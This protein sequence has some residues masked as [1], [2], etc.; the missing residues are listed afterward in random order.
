MKAKNNLKSG[1]FALLPIIVFFFILR[2]I[3]NILFSISNNF[4]LLLPKYWIYDSNSEIPF[5]WHIIAIISMLSIVWIIGLLVNHYY[6]GKKIRK[7]SQPMINKIPVLNTLFRVSKQAG[8]TL[9]NKN[10]FKEVVLVEFPVP[11]VYSIGFITGANTS[12][13]EN[14]LE[15]DVVSVFSPTTPNPT[16]GFLILVKRNSVKKI[17]MSVQEAIEYIIS[18]GTVDIKIKDKILVS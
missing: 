10:S 3:F 7:F 5:Y 16:N 8:D 17:D 15:S 13:F 6:V 14:I 12:I 11:G 2:W 4:L 9:N 1:I 18:M